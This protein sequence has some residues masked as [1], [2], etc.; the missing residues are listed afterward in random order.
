MAGLD[1]AIHGADDGEAGVADH[2]VKPGDD[3]RVLTA[4]RAMPHGAQRTM[5]HP[6]L[7]CLSSPQSRSALAESPTGPAWMR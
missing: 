2:R 6:T 5:M 1:P 4:A 7:R 3:D